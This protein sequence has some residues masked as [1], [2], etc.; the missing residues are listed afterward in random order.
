MMLWEPVGPVMVKP[1]PISSFLSFREY[2]HGHVASG[3]HD[4]GGYRS[5]YSS[6]AEYAMDD[7]DARA[8]PGGPRRLISY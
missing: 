6:E 8:G 1:G 5:N 4:S 7:T 2:S 3:K